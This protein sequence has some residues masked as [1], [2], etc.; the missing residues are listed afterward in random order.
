M[1]GDDPNNPRDPDRGPE[2][3]PDDPDRPTTNDDE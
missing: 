2:A 1:F 3:S